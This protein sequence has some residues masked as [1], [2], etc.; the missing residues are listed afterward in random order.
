IKLYFCPGLADTP[1]LQCRCLYKTYTST[2]MDNLMTFL[3]NLGTNISGFFTNMFS[4]N[5]NGT[6]VSAPPADYVSAPAPAPMPPAEETAI[7]YPA[8]SIPAPTSPLITRGAQYAPPQPR[9]S[10]TMTID[11]ASGSLHYSE[12]ITHS[13]TGGGFG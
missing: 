13:N 7:D 10:G 3:K 4:A 2:A 12:G 6:E 5:T 8:G 9:A 11:R 1:C